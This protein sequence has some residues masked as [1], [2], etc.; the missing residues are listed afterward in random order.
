[1]RVA[2]PQLRAVMKHCCIGNRTV[3]VLLHLQQL[4]HAESGFNPVTSIYYSLAR[5]LLGLFFYI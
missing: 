2:S 5:L 4:I 3:S 1:M